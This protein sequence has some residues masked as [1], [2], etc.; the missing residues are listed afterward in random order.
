MPRAPARQAFFF[1][2]C[3]F[4]SLGLLIELELL[5]SRRRYRQLSRD[6][7]Q[8]SNRFIPM[9]SSA[10]RVAAYGRRGR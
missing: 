2:E 8:L 6:D 5:N 7:Y 3:E 4:A 9:S 10:R 1:G